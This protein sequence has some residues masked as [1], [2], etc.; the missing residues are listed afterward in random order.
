MVTEL[1][2]V[3]YHYIREQAP[4]RGIYNVTPEF[5]AGQLDAIHGNGFNFIAL[6]D[7][8]RAMRTRSLVGLP[9]K[10]CLVTFDDGLR[11]SYELGL[12]IMDRM[13]IPGAF[14]L[15]SLTLDRQVV[16]D[17]HK[18]HHV[19]AFLSNDDIL[20]LIPQSI[21]QRLDA[22]D[23]E[24]IAAQ[25]TWDDYETGRL[26][27]LFNF[28][29]GAAE[30]DELISQLFALC[31]DVEADFAADL[32]M[33]E[34]QVDELS[35]RGYLGSHGRMHLPL[36]TLPRAQIAD[37]VAGSK[38]AITA[39]CGRTVDAI[40]YPY[41]GE[42][43]ISNDVICEAARN[44][45]VSGV[46]MIRGMNAGSEIID[47]PLRLRRFDTNDVFGGKSEHM[48]KRYFHE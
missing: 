19:Q 38:N 4:V 9:S 12:S 24:V 36:A 45:F 23:R 10:A 2:I 40:S 43:A 5:F 20:G 3:N 33:T 35:R 16:L 13:G 25:Y 1:L 29:L 27:Y 6:E 21:R 30:K 41:G 48:Y 11:E 22:V 44:G 14:Y 39:F 7:I 42:T 46:T 26:K 47:N 17:V 37:E 32:Y 18:F 34:K 15:S 8:H 31:V 28:L